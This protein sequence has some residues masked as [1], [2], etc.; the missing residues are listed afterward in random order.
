MSTWWTARISR[1]RDACARLIARAVAA[2][3]DLAPYAPLIERF[4]EHEI[5]LATA[6][7]A[8]HR[9]PGPDSEEHT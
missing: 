8:L 5:A 1:E 6:T 3:H 4:T 2:G 9:N 7:P